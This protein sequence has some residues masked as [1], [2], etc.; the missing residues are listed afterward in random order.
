MSIKM[1]L[2]LIG[3]LAVFLFIFKAVR[4]VGGWFG[5]GYRR[6]RRADGGGSGGD[7]HQSSGGDGR[8]HRPRRGGSGGFE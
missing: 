1:A 2:M 6:P 7:T 8:P 5:P 4:T 3:L